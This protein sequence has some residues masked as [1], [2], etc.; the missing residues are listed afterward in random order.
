MAIDFKAGD[1]VVLKSGGPPMTVSKVHTKDWWTDSATEVD[2][3]TQ[4]F[5]GTTNVSGTFKAIMLKVHRV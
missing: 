3:D 5:N 2:V 4:W 1:V